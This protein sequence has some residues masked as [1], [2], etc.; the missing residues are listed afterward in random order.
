MAFSVHS[1]LAHGERRTMNLKTWNVGSN[2]PSS[3][4][5][6]CDLRSVVKLNF[7]PLF[8]KEKNFA[9]IIPEAPFWLWNVVI[10]K[11]LIISQILT[12]KTNTIK[13]IIPCIW[14]S[15]PYMECK[16]YRN[17]FCSV[18]RKIIKKLLALI[19]DLI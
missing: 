18:D 1:Q 5:H 16:S 2:F 14:D 3:P 4:N 15:D 10:H 12:F 7:R 13:H 11:Q 9:K 17:L 8:L 6:L 19:N